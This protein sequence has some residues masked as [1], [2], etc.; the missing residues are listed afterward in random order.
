MSETSNAVRRMFVA[1]TVILA[2]AF[3][4]G[5]AWADCPPRSVPGAFGVGCVPCTGLSVPDAKG[6]KCICPSSTFTWTAASPLNPVPVC[7]P[8]ADG[9]VANADSSACVPIPVPQCAKNQ[10][11]ATVCPGGQFYCCQSCPP[12]Q[13]WYAG[14]YAG[15]SCQYCQVGSVPNPDQND[16][17]NPPCIPCK[18]GTAAGFGSQTCSACTGNTYATSK[19]DQCIACGNGMVANAKHSAC[20]CPGGTIAQQANTPNGWST[21]CKQCPPNQIPNPS[22]TKCVPCPAGT[23]RQYGQCVPTKASTT[24]V[25]PSVSKKPSPRSP[26]HP[27]LLESAPGLNTQGPGAIGTPRGAGAGAGSRPGG[28]NR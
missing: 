11:V 4:A 1:L 6:Q 26:I 24:P 18:T 28:M 15:N 7:S 16:P 12:G 10:H 5:A 13:T 22:Q 20:G 17:N 9:F 3:A 21:Y 19:H 25:V 23:T 8:C 2:F 14:N 27:G